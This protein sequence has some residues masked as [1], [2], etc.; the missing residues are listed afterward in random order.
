ML[1]SLVALNPVRRMAAASSD[2]AVTESDVVANLAHV[3][4]IISRSL[5][6]LGKK[7]DV[8]LVA[9]SKTKPSS[10]IQACY[11]TGHRDF[12]ENYVQEIV[13]KAP[14][15]PNDI[16]WHF[17]GH[18]QSNKVKTLLAI[19]NLEFVET[20]DS[21]KLAKTLDKVAG[22]MRQNPLNVFVQI[23][24]SGE[25]NK[26]GVSLGD[27]TSLLNFIL[28]HCKHLRFRGL[29][30]IGDIGAS[31]Q[32]HHTTEQ[33]DFKRLV[34]CLRQVERDI[35]TLSD[36]QKELSMG[37]SHDYEKAIE[38]G[39]TNVRVGSIIFGARQTKQ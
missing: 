17:I 18:L 37:M 19:P 13:D 4:E 24:T 7:Q 30:T 29:M 33:P 25:E 38:M 6:Q 8:R 9:V 1:R 22:E 26:S 11:N 23:N 5:S 3:K 35:P 20:V 34:E 21:E 28:S 31:L 39:S 10:L 32:A 14:Q 16:R 12:G 36:T 27:C 15:L 2:L